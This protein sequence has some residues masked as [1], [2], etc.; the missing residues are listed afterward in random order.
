MLQNLVVGDFL[1]N[2]V[3]LAGV[4]HFVI[5]NVQAINN[6]EYGL[7]PVFSAFGLISNCT[8]QGSNDTGIY[9]GQSNEIVLAHNLVFDNVNGLEIENSSI[10]IAE[11]NVSRD[12]TVGILEDLLPGLAGH[13]V[14]HF[15]I[16]VEGQDCLSTMNC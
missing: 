10:V 2:G 16:A 12:N 4:N 8:A 9:V 7:F 3:L 6:G 13:V 15:T 11:A 5:S 1:E 14:V